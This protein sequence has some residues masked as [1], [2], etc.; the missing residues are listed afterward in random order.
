MTWEG[1]A[2]TI[3]E[4]RDSGRICIKRRNPD[5]VAFVVS[6]SIVRVCLS[7]LA[8]LVDA[9]LFVGAEL[10][11]SVFRSVASDSRAG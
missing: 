9:K 6:Q 11:T 2:Y 4:L 7:R 5:D 8:P 1:D 3:E 10:K